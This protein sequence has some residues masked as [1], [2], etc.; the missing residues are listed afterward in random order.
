MNSDR[1]KS[2]QVPKYSTILEKTRKSGCKRRVIHHSSHMSYQSNGNIQIDRD[3]YIIACFSF[4]FYNFKNNKVLP[5][6]LICVCDLLCQM[7]LEQTQ[8]QNP[9]STHGDPGSLAG[10]QTASDIFS[11][12]L[13]H[14]NIH[15]QSKSSHPAPDNFY[16]NS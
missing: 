11:R 7:V 8:G 13:Q 16:Q 4:P 3:I 1:V 6:S 14:L 9:I 15:T 10:L 2:R 12:G 5:I